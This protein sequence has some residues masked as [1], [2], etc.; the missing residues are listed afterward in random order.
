MTA[1]ALHRLADQAIESDVGGRRVDLV[2]ASELDHIGDQRAELLGSRIEPDEDAAALGRRQVLVLAQDLDVR[3]QARDRRAELVGGVGDELA[4][5]A[6]RVG[7][8]SARR[9][10]GGQHRVE[11]RRQPPDLVLAPRVDPAAQ[12]PGLADV[13]RGLGQ[14]GDRRDRAGRETPRQ[15]CREGDSAED[16][17]HQHDAQVRE[18]VVGALERAGDLQRAAVGEADGDH[19]HVLAADVGVGELLAG[20]ARGDLARVAVDR[21]L[22]ARRRGVVGH[23]RGAEALEEDRARG[24]ELRRPVR[25]HEHV[26]RDRAGGRRRADLGSERARLRGLG[27]ERVVGLPAELAAHGEVDDDRGEADRERHRRGG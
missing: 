20:A 24:T 10:E 2:A 27:A 7:E 23:P 14:L 19:A 16:H 26:L 21:D 1:G 4:L 22:A 8:R 6:D 12:V 17:E 3:A 15:Q 18:H 9:L 5:G 13:L 25:G 11:A